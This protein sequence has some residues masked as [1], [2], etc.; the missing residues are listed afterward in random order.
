[1][2]KKKSFGKGFVIEFL[3][4]FSI[5]EGHL[6]VYAFPKGMFDTFID[7]LGLKDKKDL[8]RLVTSPEEVELAVSRGLVPMVVPNEISDRFVSISH[9]QGG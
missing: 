4:I 5:V 3:P 2:L 6:F 8:I 9:L 1:M 7:V